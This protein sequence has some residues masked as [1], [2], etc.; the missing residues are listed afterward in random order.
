MPCMDTLKNELLSYMGTNPKPADYDGYWDKAIAE[1]KA[2]DP[3][4]EFVPAKFKAPGI[5]CYDMYFNGAH[6]ARIHCKHLRPAGASA[7]KKVP[8]VLMFHG[9][10]DRSG[11]WLQKLGYPAAGFSLFV[12]DVRGQGGESQDVGGTLGYT[13]SGQFI[14]GLDD[15]DNDKMF[16]RDVYLDTAELAKI[17]FDLDFTDTSRVYATGG[18]QG[19]ALTLAC[20]AL[21]PRIKKAGVMYPF[22]CDFKKVWEMNMDDFAYG[23]LKSYFRF[24]DPRHEREDEI[25]TKLGYIDIQ[26]IVP[27]IKA[28]VKLYSGLR[29]VQCSPITYFAAYNKITSKKEVTF[30]PE[31][32]HEDLPGANDEIFEWFLQEK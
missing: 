10:G 8:A 24:F 7:D 31:F 6:G 3:M 18:S 9:Y 26:N 13:I 19:G 27:R 12:M 29:D 2:I 1:M 23:E 15:P 17:V 25:F 4:V 30:Y 14:R 11:D 20:A 28:E 21:E 32:G 5:E 16:F 22:L